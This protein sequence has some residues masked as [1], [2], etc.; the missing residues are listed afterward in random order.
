[1]G[2][3]FTSALM[4]FD[5]WDDFVSGGSGIWL[6]MLTTSLRDKSHSQ[7]CSELNYND[8]IMDAHSGG[9]SSIAPC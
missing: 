4:F 6:G 5:V 9:M 7:C 1:M 2:E 8:S 3:M